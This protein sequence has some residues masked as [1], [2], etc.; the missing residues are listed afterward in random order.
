MCVMDVCG[1]LWGLV[2]RLVPNPIKIHRKCRRSFPYKKVNIRQ[3]PSQ[4][5]TILRH[6]FD[7]H[8]TTILCDIVPMDVTRSVRALRRR[9]CVILVVGVMEM[10]IIAVAQSIHICCQKVT[11][12]AH[13]S[14]GDGDIKKAGLMHLS[15]YKLDKSVVWDKCCIY[16]IYRSNYQY[17]WFYFTHA[18]MHVCTNCHARIHK[19]ICMPYININYYWYIH[20]ILSGGI[21]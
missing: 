18:Y 3:T 11:E 2:D 12:I 9:S 7:G 10:W 16:M 4:R 14:D 21:N 17:N 19:D 13:Y 5:H 20:T 15:R 6:I 8:I 1:T